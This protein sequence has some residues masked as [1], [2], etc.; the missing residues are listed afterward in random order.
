MSSINHW[1]SNQMKNYVTGNISSWMNM[2]NNTMAKNVPAVTNSLEQ[3]INYIQVSDSYVVE[4]ED[5]SNP[6]KVLEKYL[7]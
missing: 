7:G 5:N 4:E 6:A 2:S 3:N 1:V